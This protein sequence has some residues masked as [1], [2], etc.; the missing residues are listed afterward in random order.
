M[1]GRAPGACSLCVR[2][3]G[4]AC[5]EKQLSFLESERLSTAVSLLLCLSRRYIIYNIYLINYIYIY[6]IEHP[7]KLLEY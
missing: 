6:I 7:T 3:T 5:N 2:R 4:L 1:D